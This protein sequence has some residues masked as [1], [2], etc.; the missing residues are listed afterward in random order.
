MADPDLNVVP[1]AAAQAFAAGDERLTLTL[2]RRARNL[3]PSG[4]LAWA[5]LERLTGLVLIHLQREVEG[6]FALERAD[7]VLDEL[8]A[9]YPDLDWLEG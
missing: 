5:Q 7:A 6:T 1:P 3:H 9:D 4:S 8:G 2:L